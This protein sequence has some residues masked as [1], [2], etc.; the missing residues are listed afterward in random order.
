MKL[1][2]P[3]DLIQFTARP[4]W[5]ATLGIIM[6]FVGGGIALL[7]IVSPNVYI[8]GKVHPGFQS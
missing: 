4:R 7:S 1:V 6:I 5:Y 8:L 2:N 3:Y